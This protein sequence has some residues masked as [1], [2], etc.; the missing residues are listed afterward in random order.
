MDKSRGRVEEGEGG[1]FSWGGVEGGGEKT[2]NCNWITI[3][4]KKKDLFLM[5][6][7]ATS[8][9][10]VVPFTAPLGLFSQA[11]SCSFQGSTS[12]TGD[13]RNHLSRHSLLRAAFPPNIFLPCPL[14]QAWILKLIP[15]RSAE[16]KSQ[17]GNWREANNYTVTAEWCYQG[18]K[19]LPE[20]P[21]LAGEGCDDLFFMALHNH[22][23]ADEK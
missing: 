13:K 23:M 7:L 21:L 19:R 16:I 18:S 2:Y 14:C 20:F 8:C 12:W 4:I 1:G 15:A 6:E 9:H 11:T 22:L 3:K 10:W 5:S 17:V